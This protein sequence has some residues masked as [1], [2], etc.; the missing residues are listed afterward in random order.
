MNIK[1]GAATN[2]SQIDLN[3]TPEPREAS[4]AGAL[5]SQSAP[6]ATD[7][8]AL[9]NTNELVQQALTAGTEVR[10]ARVQ[11]LKQLYENNQYYSDPVAV[12]QSLITAHIAGE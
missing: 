2:A 11:E 4:R 1:T 5:G 8:I 7:S 10:A 6:P 3:Q 12:S 9:S